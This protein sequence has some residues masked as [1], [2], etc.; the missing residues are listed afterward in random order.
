MGIGKELAKINYTFSDIENLIE[1]VSWYQKDFSRRYFSMSSCLRIFHTNLIGLD[2]GQE[3]QTL[4]KATNRL[5]EIFVK[6]EGVSFREFIF[7]VPYDEVPLYIRFKY[8][9]PFVKWRLKI[10]K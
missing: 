6:K 9:E 3:L 7:T 1:I 5:D 4:A 8:L 10:G 2:P